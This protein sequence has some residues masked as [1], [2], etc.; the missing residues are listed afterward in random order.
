M[1]SY[2][3]L[4]DSTDGDLDKR[5]DEGLELAL[6]SSVRFHSSIASFCECH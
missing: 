1:A 2:L 6:G 5:V 4:L 3:Y